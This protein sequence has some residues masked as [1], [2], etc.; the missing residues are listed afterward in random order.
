MIDRTP[1]NIWALW[2]VPSF[3]DDVD[4]I[5]YKK[6]RCRLFK[7]RYAF[8]NDCLSVSALKALSGGFASHLADY[9]YKGERGSQDINDH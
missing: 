1:V 2:S 4:I 6:K 3:V 8:F 7:V 5:S 9:R